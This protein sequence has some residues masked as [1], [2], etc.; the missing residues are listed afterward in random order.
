MDHLP[1]T[2]K[3]QKPALLNHGQ[4]QL[5]L[6]LPVPQ[7]LTTSIIP[8]THYLLVLTYPRY[9]MAVASGEM[10]NNSQRAAAK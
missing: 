2:S 3:R 9:K 8:L 4:P 5:L 6:P 10:L 1:L 7:I